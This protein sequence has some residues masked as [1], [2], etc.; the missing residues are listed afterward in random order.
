MWQNF[1]DVRPTGPSPLGFLVI[2]EG[3]STPV[4][5]QFDPESKR[6]NVFCQ[7]IGKSIQVPVKMWFQ[8]PLLP[9]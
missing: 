6:F 9:K 8:I 3:C 2:I 7:Q 1:K 5:G 4:I